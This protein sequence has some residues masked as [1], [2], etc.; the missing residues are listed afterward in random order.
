MANSREIETLAADIGENVYMELAK[1]HL[2]LS[3][4]HL[5]TLVAEQIYPLLEDDSL[6]KAKVEQILREITVE[7]GGGKQKLSLIDFIPVQSQNNLWDLL[8]EFKSNL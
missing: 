3:D 2:Y 8:Q 4:A 7:I 5:H 6:T 1:W